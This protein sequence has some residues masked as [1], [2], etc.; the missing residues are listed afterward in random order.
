MALAVAALL[1]TPA[2]YAGQ[3]V[4]PRPDLAVCQDDLSWMATSTTSPGTTPCNT[5]VHGATTGA[6]NWAAW[7]DASLHWWWHGA[8]PTATTID[9]WV[10]DGPFLVTS[11]TILSADIQA[12][13]SGTYPGMV[14]ELS[15][16]GGTTWSDVTSVGGTLTPAYNATI[17]SLGPLKYRHVYQGTISATTVTI[18]LT[19][20]TAGSAL[21]R[22]RVGSYGT[23]SSWG[24]AVRNISYQYG[25]LTP[26]T[27]GSGWSDNSCVYLQWM[28][29]ND[30]R[31]IAS[32]IRG[33][34]DGGQTWTSPA[35]WTLYTS[36]CQITGLVNGLSY[37][38]EVANFDTYGNQSAPITIGPLTP[39]CTGYP[40]EPLITMTIDKTQD[41]AQV[42]IKWA[43]QTAEVPCG[44]DP[45][46]PTEFVPAWGGEYSVRYAAVSHGSWGLLASP[47]YDTTL[48][49]SAEWDYES[50]FFVR[51]KKT[52]WSPLPP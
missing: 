32:M 4:T 14:I 20:A 18:D 9:E 35:D 44:G 31:V 21:M 26:P 39:I 29:G 24:F 5:W 30:S 52:V 1:S 33:S 3:A 48:T 23:T 25:D 15:Y 10:Y 41:P 34:V 47:W 7:Q 28:P 40:P 42:T 43:P 51:T 2:I 38:F 17:G 49:F 50:F 8:I 11:T 16:D 36:P 19:Q 6:D 12:T 37:T 45:G 13:S 46:Y 27:C 22:F